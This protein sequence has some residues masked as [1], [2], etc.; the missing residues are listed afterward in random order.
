MSGVK[1]ASFEPAHRGGASLAWQRRREAGE[2]MAKDAETVEGVPRTVAEG[3]GV[4]A[5]LR[6]LVFKYLGDGSPTLAAAISFYMFFSLPPLLFVLLSLTGAVL[7]PATA[8]QRVEAE[9]SGLIGPQGAQQIAAMVEAVAAGEAG[10]PGTILGVVAL[11]FG[12]TASFAQLQA[13]LNHSWRVQADPTRGDIR[14]FLFKRVLS[15][16]MIVSV[17]FLMLVSLLISA[18][19]AAFGDLVSAALPGDVSAIAVEVL[20]NLVTFTVVT[21]LF[22]A[23][24]RVLPDASVD[25][26]DVLA[27]AAA[28]ALLFMAGKAGIGYWL[29]SS[30]PATAYGAAGSLAIVLIWVYYSAIIVLLGASFTYVWAERQGRPVRPEKGAARVITEKRRREA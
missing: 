18:L 27:G 9:L 14:N 15:F 28:T 20:H 6:A 2:A 1:A 16:A 19:L 10:R 24:F 23:M 3:A 25:G 13:A 8:Q 11:L 17:A 4:F 26:R 7:D 29:G 21:G 12:A 5:V 22:A 30:D